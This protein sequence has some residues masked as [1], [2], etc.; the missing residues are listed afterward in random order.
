MAKP[1]TNDDHQN[2]TR[3]GLV[4][5][6]LLVDLDLFEANL[7]SMAAFAESVGIKLRPHAKTH[8]CPEIARQQI[9][10]GAIGIS[11]ATIREAEAMVDAGI[12]GILVT[13][14]IVDRPKIDKLVRVVQK[15]PDTMV[16]VDSLANAQDLNAAATSAL[17]QIDV[18]LDVDPGLHRTGVTGGEPAVALAEQIVKLESLNLRGVQC[19]SGS[20]AHIVGWDA[21]KEHSYKAM[22]PGL[23]TMKRLRRLGLVVDILSGGSTGTYNIDSELEGVTELQPGSYVFM[24]VDYH[25][26]GGK[27]GEVYDDFARSLTV[28]STV[29]SRNHDDRATID[30]GIK[31]FATDRK[32]GPEIKDD[33]GIKYY[34]VGDEH[35]VL[36][37]DAPSRDVRLGDRL[38]FFVPHCD[39]T[40][41]L[42]DRIYCLRGNRVEAVWP[43]LG[44]HG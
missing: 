24:D 9:E 15:A 16:V 5:P 42:Y 7:A 11:V 2:L 35:G 23:E 33:T 18:L 41:N 29:I 44:R 8:K 1:G 40:V 43:V 22:E 4:T 20:S 26:I 37:F 12:T 27:G 19:Y 31:A 21:R 13:S 30:A 38:E 39:P 14:E 25:R 6:A 32:F 10:A 3:D 34:F 17:I 36:T 28:L